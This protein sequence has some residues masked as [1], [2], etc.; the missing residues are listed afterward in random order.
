MKKRIVLTALT[1]SVMAVI[2]LFSSQTGSES[3]GM[4]EGLQGGLAAL[5]S[6]ILGG[7]ELLDKLISGSEFIVRKSAHF[8]LFLLLGL[9]AAPTFKNYGIEK[10]YLLTAVIFCFIYAVS[11][12][13]HQYFVEGRSSEFRD[14]LIDTAG[15]AAGIFMYRFISARRRSVS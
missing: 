9:F 8:T 1:L 7:G 15:S 4:S 14:V 10:R 13:T 2:F 3:E 6:N 11:D 12:E 5:L